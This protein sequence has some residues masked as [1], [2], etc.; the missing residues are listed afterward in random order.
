MP[1][2]TAGLTPAHPPA[3]V[4]GLGG[5]AGD[6]DKDTTFLQY[7]GQGRGLPPAGSSPCPETG[8]PSGGPGSPPP[9]Q[10]CAG[11]GLDCVSERS[12]PGLKVGWEAGAG[13]GSEVLRTRV[14]VSSAR[15][16]WAQQGPAA[17][18]SRAKG[19]AGGRVPI[20]HLGPPTAH[21]WAQPRGP[22]RNTSLASH[23]PFASATRTLLRCSLTGGACPCAWPAGP[24][25]LPSSPAVLS[26]PHGPCL[27]QPLALRCSSVSTDQCPFP[28]APHIS[29]SPAA[30][31]QGARATHPCP[32]P[33]PGPHAIP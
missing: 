3:P 11:Q 31:R 5:Q 33:Q 24:H 19:I 22:C 29:R 32:G 2:H 21:H 10:H 12:V 13:E 20:P 14:L 1:P 16:L 4:V 7:G 26:Q 28:T 8:R 6:L 9:P 25:Q 30:G 18:S 17:P 15:L 27:S 23:V